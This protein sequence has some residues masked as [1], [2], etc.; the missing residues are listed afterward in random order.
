[1]GCVVF[2]VA[3]GVNIWS[4]DNNF[5]TP[6]DV[7]AIH[8]RM[9]VVSCLDKAA[10]DQM[11]SNV[12]GVKKQRESAIRDA[13][14]RAKRF[15]KS[16]QEM[17]VAGA[18]GMKLSS[19]R[20]FPSYPDSGT[21]PGTSPSYVSL[22]LS[23]RLSGRTAVSELR[24]YSSNFEN[25]SP[26]N[27]G[28]DTSYSS[29]FETGSP[30]YVKSASLLSLFAKKLQRKPRP[31][32]SSVSA[33]GNV[34]VESTQTERSARKPV[35][36]LFGLPFNGTGPIRETETH[37]DIER[38]RPSTPF[39]TYSQPELSVHQGIRNFGMDEL[40]VTCNTQ[41]T[42]QRHQDKDPRAPDIRPSLES[43]VEEKERLYHDDRDSNDQS[44]RLDNGSA[45]NGV[46][47][48]R[49]FHEGPKA[50]NG[51][52]NDRDKL[53]GAA[54]RFSASNNRKRLGIIDGEPIRQNGSS[55]N[56][57]G[58]ESVEGG[59]KHETEWFNNRERF[60]RLNGRSR[61]ETRYSND[62]DKDDV[63]SKSGNGWI[64][65]RPGKTGSES[66]ALDRGGSTLDAFLQAYGLL[67]YV[68]VLAR[69]KL[70]MNSLTLVSDLDLKDLGIPLGPR[71]V[72][73]DAVGRRR[74]T[75]SNPGRIT[76]STF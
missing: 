44:Y 55:N 53:D 21:R 33:S 52:S 18:D 56:R 11:S 62:G 45:T 66:R 35:G 68:P 69:E 42:E 16:Q 15:Q 28:T 63:R 34:T 61:A 57:E 12:R 24:P 41:G 73:L 9:T 17:E 7:A 58:S 5:N 25:G 32:P 22:T 67:D 38:A 39:R 64:V 1:M 48:P 2:L 40:D 75:L 36:S 14:R 19:S 74:T 10:A 71:R 4:L 51:W 70:D 72:L 13:E 23:S 37:D 60:E 29:N 8:N 59:Y 47:D 49:R 76:D 27:V 31:F 6:L 43:K 54:D 26:P 65:V 30:P 20:S 46:N 3:F 50:G